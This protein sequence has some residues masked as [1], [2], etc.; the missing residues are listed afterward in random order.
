MKNKTV[1]HCTPLTVE[2]GFVSHFRSIDM[3]MASDSTVETTEPLMFWVV[4]G[5][6]GASEVHHHVHSLLGGC[7]TASVSNDT[8]AVSRN[9]TVECQGSLGQAT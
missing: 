1:D 9:S 6:G 5:V 3:V 4:M 7:F 2:T 8:Q